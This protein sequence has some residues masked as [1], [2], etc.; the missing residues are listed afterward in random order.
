MAWGYR[1]ELD[2]L[3]TFAVVIIVFFH[4]GVAGWSNSF[5]ALDLFFVL[6][7]FLVTNVVLSEVDRTGTF[8]LGD[9]YARRVRRLL[10]AALVTI[11]A[12]SVLFV[13][14]SSQPERLEMVRQAQAALLYFANWEFIAEQADY[15]AGDIWDSPFMHFW[16]LSLEE[17]YYIVF[18][19]LVLAVLKLAA[20]RGRVMFGVFGGVAALSVISQLYWAQID[21]TRA[22]FGTD[23]RLFQLLGGAM[24][25]VAL[26]EFVRKGRQPEGGVSWPVLGPVLAVAGLA[27]Y[28]VFGSE[29]VPISVSQRNLVA[30][31]I[32]GS[33][34]VG[35]YTAPRSRV[36][37]VFSWGWV[38]WLGKIS[39]GIYLWHYPSILV[40]Q[41]IF[42][43]RPVVIAAMA[44]V[45]AT[46]MAALSYQLI[47]TPIRRRSFLDRFSWPAV[48]AGLTASVLAAVA[49]VPVVLGSARSPVLVAGG[50]SE[51]I[52]AQ[53]LAEDEKKQEKQLEA[54]V[55][56]GFDYER[57]AK[58]R[59]PSDTWCT[60]GN[61]EDCEWVDGDGLHVVLVGDSH[62]RMLTP[63][64][65]KAARQQGFKL[66]VDFVSSCPWQ[67]DVYNGGAAQQRE[68]RCLEAREGFYTETLP[69]M[70]ADVVVLSGL[71]RSSGW[72][73]RLLD[74]DGAELDLPQDLARS[75]RRTVRLINEAGANAVMVKSV[76]G[77]EGWDVEGWDPLDCLAR[78]DVQA[79]CAVTMPADR[80]LADSYYDTVATMRDDAAT[81]DINTLVCP[82]APLC[83]PT[84]KGRVVWRNNNHL[85]A[86]LT[87][88]LSEDIW[89]QVEET[90]L[91]ER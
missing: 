46:A 18:P 32:A 27:G 86:R 74:Y 17:Q 23:A 45:I 67:H 29:L 33:L 22:Y 15:F 36:G 70:D 52:A 31:V 12:V 77:T 48:V 89:E 91:A 85:T 54:G 39:Y 21:P 38:T 80:P 69:E 87:R 16:S 43:T 34:V 57:I 42:D 37:A 66:S 49:V 10:P 62:A 14:V 24:L 30:T 72:Q 78:A 3:R 7:G 64:F 60:P 83:L 50:T 11:V 61:A 1:P 26:R 19:L 73:G 51:P 65:A 55:S 90:G 9:Y 47:E 56:Q 8:R 25:A 76:M 13:L 59:G 6:S 81:I 75:T 88:F 84:M 82:D 4:A 58:D 35:L 28:A 41:R 2:G 71:A 53:S 68:E 63:A 79:E 20:G 44:G 40:L 5:I